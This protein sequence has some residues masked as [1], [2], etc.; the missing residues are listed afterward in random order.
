MK[1]WYS[2]ELENDLAYSLRVWLKNHGITF[3]TS[4]CGTFEKPMTH[5]EI[6]MDEET[7]KA[8]QEFLDTL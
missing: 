2:V 8:C 3:D 1:N 7:S 4:G 5:F 6:I